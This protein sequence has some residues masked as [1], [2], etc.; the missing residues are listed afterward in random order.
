MGEIISVKKILQRVY[1]HNIQD[2][3]GVN[4]LSTV[5]SDLGIYL[6]EVN[7]FLPTH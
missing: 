6:G 3:R 1:F 7:C 5:S 2:S 4:I